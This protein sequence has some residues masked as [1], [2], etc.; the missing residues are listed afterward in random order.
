MRVDGG[1]AVATWSPGVHSLPRASIYALRILWRQGHGESLVGKLSLYQVCPTWGG[2]PGCDQ[3][4]P[5]PVPIGPS[6]S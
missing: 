4:C 5:S 2:G 3:A 6:S 1:L